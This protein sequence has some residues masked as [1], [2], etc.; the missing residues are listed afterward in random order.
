[1]FNQLVSDYETAAIIGVFGWLIANYLTDQGEI[2]SWWRLFV[3]DKIPLR[4]AKP[5]GLCA[6]CT[7]G[8]WTTVIK[9]V[10]IIPLIQGFDL[11]VFYVAYVAASSLI[12]MGVAIALTKLLPNE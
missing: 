12:A 9:A 10:Y 7:A 1:M 3:L 6:M 4:L 5:L 2:L 8:F 11:I